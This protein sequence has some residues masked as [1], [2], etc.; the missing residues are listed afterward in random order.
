MGY[1]SKTYSLSDE[2]VAWLENLRADYGSINKGLLAIMAVNKDVERGVSRATRE[3]LNSTA[4]QQPAA[5]DLVVEL[6]REH[7]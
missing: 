2:V 1:Q 5:R 6:D 4:K 3:R 7:K